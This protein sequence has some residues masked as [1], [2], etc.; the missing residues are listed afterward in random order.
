[1]GE[2]KHS[3]ICRTEDYTYTA[4]SVITIRNISSSDVFKEVQKETGYSE[5]IVRYKNGLIKEIFSW[6]GATKKDRVAFYRYE[7]Y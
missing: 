6:D 5:E 1:M 4:N 3:D 7:Y 2:L